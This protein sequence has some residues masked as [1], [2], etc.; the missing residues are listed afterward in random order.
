MYINNPVQQFD[1]YLI[2]SDEK[3]CTDDE[4]PVYSNSLRYNTYYA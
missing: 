1:Y 2:R 3:T 4:K